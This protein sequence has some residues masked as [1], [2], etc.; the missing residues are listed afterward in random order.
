MSSQ[1]KYILHPGLVDD[2]SIAFVQQEI[3]QNVQNLKNL[4]H[5]MLFITLGHFA[6]NHVVGYAKTLDRDPENFQHRFMS[7]IT[8]IPKIRNKLIKKNYA[9]FSDLRKRTGRT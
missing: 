2:D 9:G 8:K 5:R 1:K 4:P 6:Q 3:L 7:A